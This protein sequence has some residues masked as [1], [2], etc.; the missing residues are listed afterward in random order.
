MA[1][2]PYSKSSDSKKLQVATMFNNIAGRYDL[3]NRILSFGIDIY[4][5]KKALGMLKPYKPKLMLDVA[6]GTCDLAIDAVKHLKPSQ[7]I[8]VDI[9]D[10][11]LSLGAQKLKA[12]NLD[13][14]I[15]LENGDS[16]NLRFESN[17]FDSVIVAF[18]VRNFESLEKGLAE[19]N[20]VTKPGGTLMVLEFSQPTNK[21]FA[22]L[23]WWYC[24]SLMP[25]VGKLLSKDDSAY[26]YLP[27]SVKV[28]PSGV[29]FASLL[30]QA[31]YSEVRFI[32][33]TFGVATA[34]LAVK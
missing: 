24:N 15:S 34:Y 11:M 17:F 26:R 13:K 25:F 20:R 12:Q 19:M 32:P 1:V 8:G 21:F 33:L 3:L 23:Y 10:Q 22:A 16:E 31:G 14:I 29:T 2:L 6:T 7:I 30:K 4:W 9:A 18:G 5:R 27:E 28:F